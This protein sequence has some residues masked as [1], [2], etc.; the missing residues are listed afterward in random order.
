[1]PGYQQQQV[2]ASSVKLR[3]PWPPTALSIPRG[4]PAVTVLQLPG[5]WLAAGW[6]WRLHMA[7][8]GQSSRAACLRPVVM[9]TVAVPPDPDV[10]EPA[11]A[12]MGSGRAWATEDTAQGSGSYPA[13]V[14]YG[15]VVW[16][17]PVLAGKGAALWEAIEGGAPRNGHGHGHLKVVLDPGC[18]YQ[19]W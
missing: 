17:R 11:N 8:T 12:G 14:G 13:L 1:M 5:S 9:A 3:V 6:P 15:E 2:Q 10:S 19:A 7:A 4:S 18:S 16:A